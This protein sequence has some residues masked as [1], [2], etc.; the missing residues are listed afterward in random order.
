M[1]DLRAAAKNGDIKALE[2]FMNK[3]FE[4]RGVTV[5]VTNSGSLLRILLR[6]STPPDQRLLPIVKQGLSNINPK[7]FEKAFVKAEVIGGGVIWSDQWSLGVQDIKPIQADLLFDKTFVSTESREDKLSTSKEYLNLQFPNNAAG[8]SQKLNAL[9]TYSREG[10]RVASETITPGQF[11]G[12]DACCLALI[13]LPFAFCAG[14]TDG[15]IN[16]TLER[17]G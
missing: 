1:T 16:L 9:N 17:G 15:T 8:Q 13:C 2:A 4:P 7:G 5:R 10:W 11:K 6:G 12:K 14:S 3:S